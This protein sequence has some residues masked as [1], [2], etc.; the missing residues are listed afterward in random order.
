MDINLF[1]KILATGECEWIDF[2]SQPYFNNTGKD[3]KDKTDDFVKDILCFTNT[4]RS[5]S[6]YIIIGVIKENGINKAIGIAP[7]DSNDGAVLQQKVMNKIYP[8]PKFLT[9]GYTYDNKYFDIIEIPVQWYE[10]IC[11]PTQP[12]R[13][14]EISRVYIRRGD[15]N[16][17]AN[18][19]EILRINEWFKSLSMLPNAGKYQS[20]EEL[21]IIHSTNKKEL[22]KTVIIQ[23]D[24]E[25]IQKLFGNEA[26]EDEDPTRLREYYFKNDT[27]DRVTVE[28]PLRILVGHKGIGKSALFKVA[29]AEDYEKHRLRILIRPD[30]ISE[31]A[32]E[33]VTFLQLI[34]KWKNGILQIIQNSLSSQFMLPV[35]FFSSKQENGSLVDYICNKLEYISESDFLNESA[36]Q[37]LLEFVKNKRINIYLDDLDRGWIGSKK[38]ITRLSALLNAVRDLSNE[39]PGIQFKISLRTDVYYLVR[40]SDESTDKIQGSVIWYSWTHHEILVMLIKRIE[41]FFGRTIDEKQ[42]LNS[43]QRYIAHY[44][45]SILT[46]RFEGVGKWENVPIYRVL[47]SLIRKRPRDLVKLLTLAAREARMDGSS[48]ITTKHLQAIFDE[49]SQDRLQDTIN[50]YKTELPNIERLLLSM[51]PSH[52]HKLASDNYTYTTQELQQKINNILE[53]GVFKFSSGEVADVKSLAQFLYKINFLTGKKILPTGEL[54]RKYFEES[55]YLISRFVDFGYDWEVHMAYR[56]ALHPTS[57]D[58]IFNTL[59]ND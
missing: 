47:M 2:K 11:M 1:E 7:N 5:T 34:R 33:D 56:W 40:T 41:T 28:L 4:I 16:S 13:G 9:Y 44:L 48:I 53:Q 17:I 19:D 25:T 23:F 20:L 27:F 12:L 49:Y 15:S 52:K 18:T 59:A 3:N 29:M 31:V 22:S 50:E 32:I 51:K 54:D 21:K 37:T 26:A 8:S 55:R 24:D 42:L 38:D 6:A 39:N 58:T 30:D 14:I 10:R 36:K 45:E 57:L 35:D 46:R 43:E